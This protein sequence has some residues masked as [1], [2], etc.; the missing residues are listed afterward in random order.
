MDWLVEKATELGVREI[1]P[2]LSERVVLR[3]SGER[4]D[5]RREHW[6]GIAVAACE[7]SGRNRVPLIHPLQNLS[8]FLQHVSIRIKVILSLAEGSQPLSGMGS[9]S[10]QSP[11]LVLCGPEGGLSGKEEQ[12]ATGAGFQAVSLANRVLRS[13]TAALCA[14]VILCT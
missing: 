2:L 6:R 11:T 10:D 9:R 14:A 12:A 7:Q 1:Y 5:K 4:A 3:L 8:T 13:E